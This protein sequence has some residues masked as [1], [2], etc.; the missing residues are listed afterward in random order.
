MF[1]D[2]QEP[3][4]NNLAVSDDDNAIGRKFFQEFLY[5]GG[6][7]FLRLVDRQT[8]RKGRFLNGGS[9]NFLPAAAGA[10]GLGN[11]RNNFTIRLR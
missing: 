4:R 2:V 5:F 9:G 8:G 7:D 3:G 11:Y 1:G 6:A 10:V